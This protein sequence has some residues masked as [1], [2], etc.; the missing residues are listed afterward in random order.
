MGQALADPKLYVRA[1]ISGDEASQRFILHG[2][3][4][5]R[6]QR[7]PGH[8]SRWS[9]LD[10]A[11]VPL[12]M[13]RGTLVVLSEALALLRTGTSAIVDKYPAPAALLANHRDVAAAVRDAVRGEL[14][15]ASRSP[16]SYPMATYS[17]DP[18]EETLVRRREAN[19]RAVEHFNRLLVSESL[20]NV[21]HHPAAWGRRANCVE[22]ICR[23]TEVDPIQTIVIVA[24]LAMLEPAPH[25]NR[26]VG[27]GELLLAGAG[28]CSYR[29][30]W[31]LPLVA[32][33]IGQGAS[34]ER[35]GALGRQEPMLRPQVA[36]ELISRISRAPHG[37]PIEILK[38]LYWS[39]SAWG[40][41]SRADRKQGLSRYDSNSRLVVCE[42]LTDLLR[43]E[44]SQFSEDELALM[45]TTIA[46]AAPA[47]VTK[48]ELLM[49]FTD[50]GIGLPPKVKRTAL[51]CLAL[52]LPGLIDPLNYPQNL[53]LKPIDRSF[54]RGL[55]AL[56]KVIE[57]TQS[58]FWEEAARL[59]RETEFLAALKALARA[60][61][62]V[63]QRLLSAFK[64]PQ[65]E[66][67]R[68]ARC[69]LSD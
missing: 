49:E 61:V 46:A 34:A 44:S 13:A 37:A 20:R 36:K 66:R 50:D 11:V 1:L 22:A 62:R 42:G 35:T 9:E 53:E 68:F 55:D 31:M 40:T 29:P 3:T 15:A 60:D 2:L 7:L 24:L 21:E 8:L 5:S 28:A 4:E 25:H 41:V 23:N 69:Y 30:T 54:L 27:C 45:V 56:A 32:Q 51:S 65:A 19:G 57:G 47:R 18:I 12:L 48:V 67:E 16:Q 14:T 64:G 38:T 52:E 17:F 43:R 59:W 26:T 33:A 39:V 63:E 58:W 10:Y 6:R